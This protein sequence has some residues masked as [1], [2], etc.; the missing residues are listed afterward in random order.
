MNSESEHLYTLSSELE[1]SIVLEGA[2][3]FEE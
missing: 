2:A 1:T 3:I